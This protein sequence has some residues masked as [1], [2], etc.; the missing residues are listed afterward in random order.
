LGT[1]PVEEDGSVSFYLR[2]YIPVFFQVLDE[3]GRAV[4][5]M[6]SE[7][8]TAPNEILSCIGCHEN[9][10]NAPP[11]Q[12]T[13][14]AMKRTPSTIKPEVEGSNPFSYTR[15]VQPILNNKCVS[16]HSPGKQ[17][18]NLSGE[19]DDDKWLP[20]YRN[21]R[22]YSFYYDNGDFTESKTY[23]GKFGALASRLYKMLERGHKNVKLSTE[24]MRKIS[25]WLDCNSD[26][27][28]TYENLEAQRRGEIV[29]P[30]FE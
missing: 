17:A 25:L 6:R 24:E 19:I 5:S 20:S 9:R 3:K 16:C 1:V 26:F 28:G 13:A 7:V 12:Q 8:Y 10:R 14:M 27:Y 2:P 15:L 22:P 30:I 4:Q 11:I 18:P 23:P 21:L 29:R